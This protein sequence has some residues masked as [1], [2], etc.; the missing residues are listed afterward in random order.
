MAIEANWRF[1]R[2]SK[3]LAVRK[4]LAPAIMLTVAGSDNDKSHPPTP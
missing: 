4:A 3:E 2:R 1:A